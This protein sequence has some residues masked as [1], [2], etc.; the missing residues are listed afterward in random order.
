MKTFIFKPVMKKGGLQGATLS[1]YD[2][3]VFTKEKIVITV[4]KW[5]HHAQNI[6]RRDWNS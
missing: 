1:T 2:V 5:H 3:S 4:L 6:H